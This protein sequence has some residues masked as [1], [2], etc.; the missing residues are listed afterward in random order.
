MSQEQMNMVGLQV[1][2]YWY[3]IGAASFL[4]SF[5]SS[6]CFRLEQG[7]WGSKFPRLMN[8]LYHGRLKSEYVKDALVE[9]KRNKTRVSKIPA[10]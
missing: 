10:I 8:D 3:Q 1:K 6:V 9:L 7:S 5:F 4:H 2:F